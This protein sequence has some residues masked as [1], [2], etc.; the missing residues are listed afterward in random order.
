[1]AHRPS[2]PKPPR[3]PLRKL[4]ESQSKFDRWLEQ[5]VEARR[6]VTFKFHEVPVEHHGHGPKFECTVIMVDR[7]MLLL[8][9]YSGETWW[10]QKSNIVSAGLPV[11]LP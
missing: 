5:Q 3:K 10:V 7:Y 11:R 1:M 9:F 2:A 8:E 4:P 6:P